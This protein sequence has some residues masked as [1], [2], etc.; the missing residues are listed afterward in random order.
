MKMNIRSTF[1]I[2]FNVPRGSLFIG[3]DEGKYCLKDIARL[4]ISISVLF[5]Q[6]KKKPSALSLSRKQYAKISMLHY[7]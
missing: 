6:I 5:Y 3:L 7:N 4:A 2:F 1:N